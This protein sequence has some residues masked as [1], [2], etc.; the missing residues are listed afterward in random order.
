MLNSDIF[1]NLSIYCNKKVKRW[2]YNQISWL[3]KSSVSACRSLSDS[4]TSLSHKDQS[5]LHTIFLKSLYTCI[6]QLI[7]SVFLSSNPV[8]WSMQLNYS[9]STNFN[10]QI[11]FFHTVLIYECLYCTSGFILSFVTVTSLH[12]RCKYYWF[13]TIECVAHSFCFHALCG[14]REDFN[15]P[16]IATCWHGIITHP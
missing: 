14:H 13:F 6:C 11:L 4:K 16:L 1:L 8:F 2:T 3:G 12:F 9:K 5:F 10:L 15:N 7:R